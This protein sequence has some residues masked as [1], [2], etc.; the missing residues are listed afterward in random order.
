MQFDILTIFPH[1]LDS[2]INES[3]LK[4]AQ[5]Q[6]LVQ[7]K[8]WDLRDFTKDKRRSVDDKPYGGGPGMILQVQP[9]F[10]C[11]TQIQKADPES[12][13]GKGQKSKIILMSPRG[14]QFNQKKAEELSK[15]DRIVLICG[16]YEGVDARVEKIV[17]EQISIGP[18]VL[19]GGE[20]PAVV[21]I[22]AVTRLLPGVLGSA[23]SL[24]DESFNFGRSGP[25]SR[26]LV[27]YPQY[28]RPEVFEPIPGIKW[29]VPSVLLSGDH[30]KIKK[31]RT[32]RMKSS[33]DYS[34]VD[35]AISV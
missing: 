1:I 32:K 16:R 11:C 9:I 6:S 7:F 22:E 23:D 12:F 26:H 20:L 15:L 5:E 19:S 28:T 4:R 33:F 27:E 29:R 13:Q 14:S 24:E 17:D 10:E 2:Y 25:S 35:K 21:L 8:F 34:I 18:Y 3:I 31:W 30:A